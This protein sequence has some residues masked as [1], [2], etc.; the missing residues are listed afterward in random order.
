MSPSQDPNELWPEQPGAA[1][2]AGCLIEGFAIHPQMPWLAAACTDP[3]ED[4]GAILVFDA[5]TG[6]L[7]AVTTYDYGLGWT[8]DRD[9]LRWHPGGQSLATNLSTNGIGLFRAGQFVGEVF[10]DETRDSGTSY[11]W[12]GDQL[13]SDTT[14]LFRIQQG[15]RE[16]PPW[17]PHT[18]FAPQWNATIGAAVGYLHDEG[19]TP[20]LAA[21]DPVRQ[22][23]LYHTPGVRR[24]C[25]CIWSADGRWFATTDREHDSAR[26]RVLVYGGDDGRLRATITP[27]ASEIRNLSWSR[28]GVLAV[29]STTASGAKSY[30]DII[31]GFRLAQTIDL[32]SRRIVAAHHVTDADR[33]AWSPGGE[34]LA[35]LLDGQEVQIRDAT[36]GNVLATFPAPAPLEAP[37]ELLW[38]SAQRLVRLS[39]HFVSFWSLDGRKL[40]ELVVGK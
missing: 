24:S 10:P 4:L 35:L 25:G 8:G 37:G 14:A 20:G 21:Y 3:D 29:E 28:D 32:G 34:H 18:L 16:F 7:R 1:W 31:R 40:G 17:G 12:V 39:S 38:L 13:L 19:V 33:V 11:V 23:L 2:P 22:K 5:Q 26:F 36:R 6:R 30:V 27:S 15:D 9:L